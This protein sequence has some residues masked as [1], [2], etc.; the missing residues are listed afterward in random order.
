M[1][2]HLDQ[3]DSHEENDYADESK[4]EGETGNQRNFLV[5]MISSFSTKNEPHKTN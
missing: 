1:I 4:L 5:T 2:E 3:A